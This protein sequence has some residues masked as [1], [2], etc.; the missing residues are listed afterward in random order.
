MISSVP[1]QLTVTGDTVVA[2]RDESRGVAAAHG[3]IPTQVAHGHLLTRS[4]QPVDP[5]RAAELHLRQTDIGNS[6]VIQS[7]GEPRFRSGQL[8]IA[9][10]GL[11]ATQQTFSRLCRRRLLG[12]TSAAR[13]IAQTADTNAQTLLAGLYASEA[14]AVNNVNLDTE[15]ANTVIYQNAYAASSA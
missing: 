8:C 13:R 3:T 2:Q 1:N 7:T 14:S 15:L 4:P 6:S 9:A 10:G 12:A 11:G 5:D